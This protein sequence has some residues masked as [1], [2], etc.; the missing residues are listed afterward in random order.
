MRLILIGLALAFAACGGGLNTKLCGATGQPCC[1]SNL[2]DPGAVC[3][4]AQ[5]CEACGADGQQCCAMGACNDSLACGSGVCGAALSCETNCTLG[6]ARCQ[7]NG[8]ETCTPMGVCPVWRTTI[9]VCPNGSACT[10]T[11]SSADCIETCPGACS[12]GSQLCSADG[13]RQCVSSG[14]TC[15]ML[16]PLSDNPDQPTCLT[17]AAISA[18]LAWES[19]T[20]MGTEIVDIAGDIPGSYWLLDGLGNI[21]HYAVGPWEYELNSVATKQMLHIASCGLGSRLYAAGHNGTVFRRAASVW[22]EENVGSQ[23]KLLDVACD[24]AR[25]YAVGDDG[26]LY[27][28]NGSTWTGYATGAPEPFTALTTLFGPQQVFIA[29]E[30]GSITKCEVSTLPPS[31][32][33]EAT[34]TTADLTA[35][36]ADPTSGTVFA[37]GKAGTYLQRGAVWTQIDLPGVAN[38]EKFM[39]IT[40]FYES[41]NANTWQVAVTESGLLVLRNNDV[42]E[43][44]T[45]LPEQS[46]F[47]TVWTPDNTS[48]VAAGL[49]GAQWY[50]P[51]A[52]S[53]TPFVARGG[54]KP[55][56]ADLNAVT[57]VGGGRLFAVGDNGARAQRLNGTWTVDE[58]GASTTMTLWGVA[59]RTANEVYAVGDNGTVLV[60]RYG[61]WV[62]EAEGLTTQTLAAVVLDTEHVWVLGQTQLLEK[63]FS[64]GVW[65][66][67]DMPTTEVV[68]GLAMR[69][70]VSGRAVELVVAGANCTA[71]SFAPGTGA[72][73]PSPACPVSSTFTAAAFNANGDLFLASDLGLIVHR[74]GNVLDAESSGTS[75][76]AFTALVPDGTTMWA[77]GIEGALYRRSGS[78]W[79]NT[80]TRVTNTTL[81]GGVRDDTG[82]Y[83]VGGGG[84]VLHRR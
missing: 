19:P 41:L 35:I 63:T 10:A 65:R 67:I 28:R 14:S 43:E 13:L 50:R 3:G 56:T 54:R 29:G 5:L 23:A 83:V 16:V 11:A 47:R 78:A 61:T 79:T 70:D 68:Y 32:S 62:T 33:A 49:R 71:I 59:A 22:T 64:T 1:A 76:D 74:I 53:G 52:T 45:P 73:S 48:L 40:G 60:R 12:P 55:L 72:F 17:G 24:S 77:L 4:A 9:A 7:N 82:L 21:V 26:K 2:C 31:C 38:T 30:R 36:W 15:P 46:G 69:T 27:V 39:A 18:E 57:S 34:P 66:T 25:A 75:L 37:V 80:A 42:L 84:T 6:A 51:G 81:M 8:I 20:P 44:V 58:L